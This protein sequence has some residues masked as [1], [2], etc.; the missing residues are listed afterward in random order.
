[1][2]TFMLVEQK[3]QKQQKDTFTYFYDIWEEACDGKV[4]V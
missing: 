1:M 2:D 3:N 4:T